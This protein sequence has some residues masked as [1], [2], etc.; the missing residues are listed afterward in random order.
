M[1]PKGGPSGR[2]VGGQRHAVMNEALFE[3]GYIGN[4]DERRCEDR[5][6]LLYI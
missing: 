3:K 1:D 6:G 4:F 5:R 2:Q